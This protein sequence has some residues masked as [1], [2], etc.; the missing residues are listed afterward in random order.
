MRC[1]CVMRRVARSPPPSAP[2]PQHTSHK[3]QAN[4]S[5][6][7]SL[8]DPRWA[9]LSVFVFDFNT[10]GVVH[11]PHLRKP[12]GGDGTGRRATFTYTLYLYTDRPPPALTPLTG[13]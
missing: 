4:P 5:C 12:T 3:A 7:P 2:R 1:V 6:F 8:M 9:Y 10:L 11:V 13:P